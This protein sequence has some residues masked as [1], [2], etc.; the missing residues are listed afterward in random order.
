MA[1]T[2]IHL[3]EN[4][5]PHVPVRQFVLTFPVPVRL[6]SARNGELLA[7]LCSVPCEMIEEFLKTKAGFDKDDSVQ[8]GMVTFVQRF[9]SA[10]NLNIHLHVL[11][12]DGVFQEKTTGRVKFY[13]AKAPSNDDV[14]VLVR[15]ISSRIN[16]HLVK[17]G[18]LKE[19]EDETLVTQ[20]TTGLFPEDDLHLPAMAAS[21]V[22]KIA[23]GENQ[24]KPVKR[25]YAYG[26]CWPDEEDVENTGERC[27]TSGGYSLHANTCVKANERE[28]LKKLIQYMARPALSDDRIEIVAKDRVRIKLKTPWRDGCT[29]IEMSGLEFM[30]KLVALIPLSRFHLVRYFGIL[31]SAA[32]NRSKV[33]PSTENTTPP[34]TGKGLAR[35]RKRY[36]PWAELLKKIFAIDVMKCSKC[37]AKLA[38]DGVVEDYKSIRLILECMGKSADPPTIAPA[39]PRTLFSESW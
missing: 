4:L 20:D 21:L 2:A 15:E 10:C 24:G 27:A 32:K 12:I 28:R 36:I 17:K 39:R 26:R 22:N 18:F 13:H 33:I 11:A 37:G 30:E 9:G 38:I 1:E 7:K 8:G 29:H 5:M 35:G 6:W 23:F 31:A 34:K 25:L 3:D 16:K 19:L 14:A